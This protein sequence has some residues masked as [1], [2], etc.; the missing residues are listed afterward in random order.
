MIRFV[1]THHDTCYKCSK[2]K[3]QLVKLSVSVNARLIIHIIEGQSP[4]EDILKNDMYSSEKG[5]LIS[6]LHACGPFIRGCFH[7]TP[8]AFVLE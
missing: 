6:R 3:N 1:V 4:P 7:D 5:K 2:V 8:K